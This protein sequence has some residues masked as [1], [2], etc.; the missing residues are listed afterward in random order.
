MRLSYD[1]PD[2]RVT[3]TAFRCYLGNREPKA[4]G[5]QAVK[6]VAPQEL[7]NYPFPPLNAPLLELLTQLESI[8]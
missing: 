1:Y 8:T 2:R 6:W 7:R 4:W 3:L 5:C